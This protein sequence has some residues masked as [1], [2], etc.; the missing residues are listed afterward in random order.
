M[1]YGSAICTNALASI[2]KKFSVAIV[3]LGAEFIF[4][5][6]SCDRYGS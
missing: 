1:F 3:T 5:V 6:T 2:E 4:I